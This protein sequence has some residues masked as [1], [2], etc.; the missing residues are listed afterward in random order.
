MPTLKVCGLTQGASRRVN[1]GGSPWRR[2]SVQDLFMGDMRVRLCRPTM[3]RGVRCSGG[4]FWPAAQC[5][6]P[7][8][9]EDLTTRCHL[10]ALDP[11]C[12]WS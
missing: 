7:A 2:E 10:I 12:H 11:E 6:V 9:R 4:G 1:A 5:G 8:I 3:T